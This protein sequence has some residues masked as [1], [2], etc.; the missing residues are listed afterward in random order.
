MC[1]VATNGAGIGAHWDGL[2]AHPLIGAQIADQ[3]PVVS[4]QR[5]FFGQ[6]EVIAVLHIE[7]A[8]SHHAKAWANFV[9]ELPLDLIQSQRQ[10]LVAA[11]M[12]TE[13]VCHQLFSC[14]GI[15]HIAAMAVLHAQH[16]LTVI[17]IPPGFAPQVRRLQDG[18]LN[19]DMPCPRLLLMHNIFQLAQHFEAQRQ[20]RINPGGGLFDHSGAQHQPVADDLSLSRVFLENGQKVT[21]EAHDLTFWVI[22]QQKGDYAKAPPG[23]IIH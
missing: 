13:D 16:F 19:G 20:P 9:A 6:V 11:D 23:A 10:V 15:K 7:L 8:P 2:Q 18:H 17:V 5:V 4:V 1:I 3:M 21:A 22:F 12:A 14:G